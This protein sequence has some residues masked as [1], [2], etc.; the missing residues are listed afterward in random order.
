[1]FIWYLICNKKNKSGIINPNHISFQLYIYF[2]E[3]EIEP[4]LNYFLC[5]PHYIKEP[6]KFFII[7]Y[8]NLSHSKKR[9]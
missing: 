6:K 1:M 9:S 8:E 7:I 2:L 3:S 4:K 5:L